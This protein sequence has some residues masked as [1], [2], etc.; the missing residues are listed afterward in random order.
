MPRKTFTYDGKRYDISAPTEAE[1]YEKIAAKKLELKQG[2]IKRNNIVFKSYAKSW[3]EIFKKPY[4]TPSTQNMYLRT[5]K[6]INNYIGTLRLQDI[7]PTDLQNIIT[8][9]YEKGRSK[10]HIDKI[11]LTIKQIFK[12]AITDRKIQYNPAMSLRKPRIQEKTGR[13]LT[14]DERKAILEVAETHKY[15]LWIKFMLY[16]GL[17]PSETSIVAYN[18]ID[19]ES[20]YIHIRGTKSPKADRYIPIPAPL[21]DDIQDLKG[22]GY[23]FTT[24]QGNPLNRTKIKRRWNSFKRDLDIHMGATLYRNK[25]VESVLAD[26]LKLYCLRHSFGTDGQAAGVP[27]DVLADLMGHE[28]IETTRK[29]YIDDNIQSK[30]RAKTL[31][32]NYYTNDRFDKK[33]NV[34]ISVE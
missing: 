29:Y 5:I 23:I 25:I 27:I 6:L 18:D 3:V 13:A 11:Y 26:D 1:L 16:L 12:Q 34:V 31:L 30:E 10:S 15:G 7:T 19:L 20:G 17:R 28:K 22:V 8:K 33:C 21:F 9:E 24:A 2:A 14:I 4:C 32:N